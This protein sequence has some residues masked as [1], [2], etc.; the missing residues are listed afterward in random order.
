MQMGL[1]ITACVC[2]MNVDSL[3]SDVHFLMFSS[4]RV[5]TLTVLWDTSVSDTDDLYVHLHSLYDEDR[6]T[7]EN[8]KQCEY[9]VTCISRQMYRDDFC[10]VCLSVSYSL[11]VLK[12]VIHMFLRTLLFVWQVHDLWK[13]MCYHTDS[14]ERFIY[15]NMCTYCGEVM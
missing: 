15:C 7:L 10:A 12:Q 4:L 3:S 14:K 1:G 11:G 2:F 8:C 13:T 9:C 6:I 5:S